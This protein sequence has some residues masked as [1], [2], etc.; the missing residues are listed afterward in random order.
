[1]IP[2]KNPLKHKAQFLTLT[3]KVF[4]FQ[5]KNVLKEIFEKQEIQIHTG[6]C[7]GYE[8]WI[9]RFPELL[10]AKDTHQKT[11]DNNKEGS[12]LQ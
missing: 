7:E 6:L 10:T 3:D 5:E 4:L 11:R 2:L 8:A 12:L 1:M 9:Q